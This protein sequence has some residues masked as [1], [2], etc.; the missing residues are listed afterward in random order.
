[1]TINDKYY[2]IL[3]GSIKL[4]FWEELYL[5]THLG[6]TDI[7]QWI[8]K[9]DD[10]KLSVPEYFNRNKVPFSQAQYYRYKKKLDQEGSD[11]LMDKRTRGNNRRITAEVEVYLNGYVS[12]KP[13]YSLAEIKEVLNKQFDIELSESGISRCLKRLGCGLKDKPKGQK[14]KRTY[15][16]CGGFELI[17]ALACHMGWP[18]AVSSVIKK[19]INQIK[20]SNCWEENSPEDKKLGRNKQGQFTSRYN[21]R[22]EVREKRFESIDNKR[23]DKNF[24]GMSI[25]VASSMV[26]ARKSLA[27]LALPV[28][29]NN[30]MI[31]SVNTP[32]GDMLRSVCGFNYKQSTLTKFMAELKYLGVAEYLLRHQ[33]EFWQ[34]FWQKHPIGE[35]ELPVLCYYIDGNTK[36]LWSKKRV[37][38]NKVTM[39]GRVMG[40]IETVFVHDNFGRPIY[41]E[42]Y[43]GHAPVGEYILS[44]FKKIEDALEGP[45][46]KLPVNRAIVMDAANNSVRTLRAFAAQN[47]Y[48]YI[49]SLD[50][51]QWNPRKIRH[52]GKPKRYHYGK[53]T[54]TDCEIELEDSQDEGYII[55]SR[56]IKIEWDYGKRT[57]ILTSL[58]PSIVGASCVVKS[59]FERW[60]DE[61]LQFRSMKKVACLN[62]VAGYGKKQQEDIKVLRKQKELQS[63]IETLR[64]ILTESFTVIEEQEAAIVKLVKEERKLKAISLIEKGHRILPPKEYERFQEIG[65]EIAK[66]QRTIKKIMEPQ[67]QEFKR[68]SKFE[69]EWLRLQGKEKVY[70][71]DLELDEIMTFYRVSLVNMYSYLSYELFGKNSISMNRLVHSIL[72]LPAV[73]EETK[74]I[75]KVTLK[76]NEKDPEIMEKLHE[77]ICKINELGLKTLNGKTVV[78]SVGDIDYHL[79]SNE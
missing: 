9:I 50:D 14:V 30:G 62:R 51:N 28:I 60:P 19:R 45:G 57:V 20:R 41:F 10:S 15:T 18:Q 75:K 38:K 72:H 32:M 11:S 79:I 17:S 21:R 27:M 31:R 8:K 71:V 74:E 52:E 36:P 69:R 26:I 25:S 76:Y 2:R 29:T 48:H 24:R 73:V 59:Y 53:A 66:R 63:K 67:K 61:E 55:T 34:K 42:S 6:H 33:I 77:A 12:G 22:R 37:K 1:M 13:E 3:S 68:L 5:A 7:K 70:S 46:S 16:L 54:L 43:S 35:M 49:T 56:A 58:D 65:R 64:K 23:E 44:L 39:L 4:N 47:K 78:F 40:C